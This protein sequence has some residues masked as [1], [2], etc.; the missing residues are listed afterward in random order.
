MVVMVLGSFGTTDSLSVKA[1][2]ILL[3]SGTDRKVYVFVL[4]PCQNADGKTVRPAGASTM[5]G[6]VYKF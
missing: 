2:H 5:S 1:H 4:K 3:N 6:N